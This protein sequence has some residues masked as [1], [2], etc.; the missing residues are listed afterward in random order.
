MIRLINGR[1]QLGSVL[2]EKISTLETEEEIYI[3][4]TWNIDDKKREI[5]H[6]EYKKFIDFVNTYYNKKIIFISTSS[7]KDNWYN[8]YKHLSESYLLS[9]N[10]RG[11]VV[12]LPTLIGKGIFMK[13]KKNEVKPVGNFTLLT[14]ESAAE[15]IVE[16]LFDTSIIR[17]FHIEGERISAEVVRELVCL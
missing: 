13:L 11:I 2:S 9:Y 16:K 15:I 12:R 14:I 17:S 7:Q 5:Q 8:H 1:G 10:P 3:Y 6:N 4:H